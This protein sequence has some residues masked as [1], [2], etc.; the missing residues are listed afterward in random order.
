MGEDD[1][2]RDA[3]TAPQDAVQGRSKGTRPRRHRSRIRVRRLLVIALAT[4]VGVCVLIAALQTKLIYFPSKGYDAVPTDVGLA[5]EDLTLRTADGVNI[6]AWHVPHDRAFG[7]IIFF[8]GNAGNMTSR[9]HSVKL[10]HNMGLN[11]LIIDYRGYGRSEGK[12]SETGTYEDAEAAWRYLT[13]TRGERPDH[14][15][16]FGRSLG[17]A[18]AIELATRHTPAAL[19]TEST[20]TSLTDIGRM[21]YRFL[22]VRLILSYRYDSLSKVGRITCPKLF[23]HGR[24]DTLIPLENG[25]RLFDASADPKEFI[26][27]PGGHNE[28]GFTYTPEFTKR[29]EEFLLG[30]FE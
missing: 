10:L 27:T 6:A 17:G 16:L 13:E 19:V 3:P 24:E 2:D 29:L 28:S 9:L 7:N 20:F 11:V 26:E 22:P 5:F 4:Y 14:I 8:H 25:R 30:V 21:H 15:A 12:P 23:F 1:H 18:V